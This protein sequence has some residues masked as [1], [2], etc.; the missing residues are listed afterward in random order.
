MPTSWLHVIGILA[1]E[2]DMTLFSKLASK[3]GRKKEEK[4]TDL[5]ALCRSLKYIPMFVRIPIC[6]FI[7]K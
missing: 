2:R 3:P 5:E 1:H 6:P 7:W 4:N